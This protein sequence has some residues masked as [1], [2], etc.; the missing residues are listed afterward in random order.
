[1]A[2][3]GYLC[4]LEMPSEYNNNCV[5]MGFTRYTYDFLPFNCV[6]STTHYDVKFYSAL[7]CKSRIK[8]SLIVRLLYVLND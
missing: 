6:H 8:G 4:F 7:S 5:V 1:M 2:P 3:L